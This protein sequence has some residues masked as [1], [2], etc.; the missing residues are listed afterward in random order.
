VDVSARLEMLVALNGSV[1]RVPR[2]LLGLVRRKRLVEL[3]SPEFSAA[4]V[5]QVAKQA[6]HV[7]EGKADEILRRLDREREGK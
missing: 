3:A 6:D 2:K 5:Q 7:K 1:F 4:I